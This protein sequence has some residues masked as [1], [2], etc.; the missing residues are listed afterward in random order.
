LIVQSLSA[1][2]KTSGLRVVELHGLGR[3]VNPNQ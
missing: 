1:D 3:R 2:A